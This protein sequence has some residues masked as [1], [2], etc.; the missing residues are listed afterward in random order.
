MAGRLEDKVALVTGSTSGIGKGIAREFAL[1]GARVVLNGRDEEA[2]RLAVEEISG[3]GVPEERL[4]F[5][6][7]D[8]IEEDA[9]RALV[10]AAAGHFGGLD[11]LVNNAGDFSRGDLESTTV[12]LWD[13][14]MA[15]NLRA[16]FILTREA[17]RVM[18][19]RGGGSIINIGS[20]NAYIGGANLLSYSTS[21]GALMTFTKNAAQQLCRHNIRA[22]VIN[23]GWTLTEGE[24]EVQREE[25]GREDWL[26]DA[27]ATRPF[28]R[29]LSPKD[30]AGAALYFAS[31]ESALV[32]GSV[33]VVEQYP[34]D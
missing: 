16:P 9:C 13:R 17:A 2:G 21:K 22:N 5:H 1:E 29:L 24:D 7:A 32:N 11:V 33:L 19:E 6:A 10:Q 15:L 12:E 14:Q 28:G 4:M 26:E 25:T 23:V 20:V 27:E 34:I 8:L 30:I 3:S 31:D 18:R